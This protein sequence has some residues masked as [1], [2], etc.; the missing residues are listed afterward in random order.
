MAKAT[1]QKA[2]VLVPCGVVM[3]ISAMGDCSE[4]HWSEILTII[5]EAVTPAGF[6]ATLVSGADEVTIIQKTIIQNLY[7]NPVVIVDVSERNPN[8]M[9]ELGIRLAFDKPTVIIKD[10]K[11]PYVFDTG[12]IEHLEYPRD[13]RFS[14]IVEFKRRLAE[15]V[16]ATHQ[17]Q[18]ADPNY[19]TFLRHFGRFELSKIDKTEV[20]SQEFILK[21]L[22]DLENRLIGIS[23][24]LAPSRRP[25]TYP[26][27][28]EVDV[29]CGPL[30]ESEVERLRIKIA[31]N[32]KVSGVRVVTRGDHVHLYAAADID[33]IT[34]RREL[35]DQFRRFARSIRGD[36]RIVT[37]DQ[38]EESATDKGGISSEKNGRNARRTRRS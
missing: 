31:Q 34:D 10:D 18:I 37:I 27:G 19:S 17:K 28:N 29:C 32:I 38:T 8:V 13:L 15:K 16:L 12:V 2:K 4:S 25:I 6:D 33:S 21:K 9:F 3:P 14:K 30:T 36:S 20:S 22:D 24:P 23:A 7:E 35:E 5:S 11:T 1:E 26:A